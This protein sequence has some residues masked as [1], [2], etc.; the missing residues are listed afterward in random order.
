MDAIRTLVAAALLLGSATPT[1]ACSTYRTPDLRSVLNADTVFLGN[2]IKEKKVSSVDDSYRTVQL[3]FEPIEPLLG[4]LPKTEVVT[5]VR[6]LEP[7]DTD[8]YRS[9]VAKIKPGGKFV[10]VLQNVR[11]S[12]PKNSRDNT[13]PHREITYRIHPSRCGGNI[14][15]IS[16]ASSKIGRA[17]QYIFN[18]FGHSPE[19]KADVLAD[20]LGITG[21]F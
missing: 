15:A 5:I 14:A 9:D 3:Q 19:T 8:A 1:L 10:V 12:T 13:D 2:F 17:I 7:S 4:T 16:D 18:G 21:N 20:F 6:N 11:F